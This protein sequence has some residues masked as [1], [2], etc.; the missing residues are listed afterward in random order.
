MKKRF[1]GLKGMLDTHQDAQRRFF[2]ARNDLSQAK[3][4]LVD[5]AVQ[6]KQIHVLT[7]NVRALERMERVQ[8]AEEA[9]SLED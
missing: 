7:V 4:E 8:R 3:Y 2:E 1:N 5:W 6:Y 9:K